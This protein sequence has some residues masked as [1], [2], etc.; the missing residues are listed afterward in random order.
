[1]VGDTGPSSPDSWLRKLN[2]ANAGD[3]HL[4]LSLYTNDDQSREKYSETLEGMF[5]DVIPLSGPGNDVLT[6]DVDV[7]I[8]TD[9]DSGRSSTKV[10]F[11][12]TDGISSPIIDAEGLPPLRPLQLPYVPAWQFLLRDGEMTS[13][14]MPRPLGFAQNAS[15]SAFRILEQDVEAFE[16]FLATAEN[17]DAAELLAAK[18]CGRWR[19]GNPLVAAPDAPGKMLP[20]D[21]LR[22]FD[23]GT[24][25]TGEPCPYSAHTRRV[26]PRGGPGVTGVQ[27]THEDRKMHSVMRRANAYGPPYTGTPDGKPRGLAGHFIGASLF[28]QFEFLMLSW[29]NKDDFAG[30]RAQ[31]G[32]DPLLGRVPPESTFTYWADGKPK[33]V[34]GM[35]QFVTTRG[36][37]YCM[38]PSLTG[39]RWIA[40]NGNASDPWK[41]PPLPSAL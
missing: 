32:I 41:I 13:Y 6:F 33:T 35:S 37:L 26:N 2:R 10:H 14:N 22:D 21:Q 11:G 38:L 7:M 5:H 24:D 9:P 15:F 27:N 40:A 30:L 36:G 16:A 19:N 29:V 20:K 1:V 23:Y 12:Y 25:T 39:I 17:S 8:E 31:A 4:L 3:A 28:E 18:M 34:T